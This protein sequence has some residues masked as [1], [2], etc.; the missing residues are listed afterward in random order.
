[1]G[2]S[3]CTRHS[4]HWL[5]RLLKKTS[6]VQ[7]SH[8]A[9]RGSAES[10]IGPRLLASARDASISRQA[11]CMECCGRGTNASEGT[12]VP[13]PRSS[14]AR[15]LCAMAMASSMSAPGTPATAAR[16]HAASIH[17]GLPCCLAR[18]SSSSERKRL[19]ASNVGASL[20]AAGTESWPPRRS[21][22]ASARALSTSWMETPAVSA[23]LQ[24]SSMRAAVPL[25]TTSRSSAS[26]RKR[27]AAASAEVAAISKCPAAPAGMGVSQ[28]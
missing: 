11:A 7:P 6:R 15:R 14:S 21:L 13:D 20:P 5:W 17:V 25:A 24:A 4:W 18:P 16:L 12:P 22:S 8:R 28:S 10:S 9:G 19:A 1:M 23:R 3:Y 26:A 27:L 2:T